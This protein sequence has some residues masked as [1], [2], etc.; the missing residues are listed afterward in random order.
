MK[1]NALIS[2]GKMV[3]KL[4][5]WMVVDQIL[6][7]LSKISSKEPAVLMAVLGEHEREKSPCF[8]VQTG[9]RLYD[10]SI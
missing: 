3:D 1:V 7:T 5:R 4:E 10:I 9:F 8:A 6:P 2:L